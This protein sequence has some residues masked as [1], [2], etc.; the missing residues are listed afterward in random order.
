MCGIC[1]I[2]YFDP[3]R[4]V[5]EGEIRF[6][7]DAQI[8]RGPDDEGLFLK[9]NIGLGHRRLS[10]ID[11]EK[12]HQPIF[13][14]D[15]SVVTLLNGEIYNFQ[16]I[17]NELKGFGHRFVTD[18][19]T[20]ILVHGYEE[21]GL[22]N[23][24][25][26][27]NGMFAFCL[28]DIRHER[29]F[30]V[31]D[32]L[33]K[34]PLYY[35][36]REDGL[37]FAS[38]IRGMVSG[39]FVRK[40]INPLALNHYVRLHYSFGEESLLK[41]I[42]RVMPGHLI[43]ID[44]QRRKTDNARYWLL[45][46]KRTEGASFPELCDRLYHLLDDSV[47]LRRIADVPV[48]TFLSGGL[49]STLVT[50]LLAQ[51]IQPLDTFSIGFEESGFDES[52]DSSLASSH[53]R[54][55]HHPFLLTAKAFADL[56]QEVLIRVD[57]PVADAACIPTYWLSRE[58]RKTVKVVLTGEGADEL[59]AGYDYYQEIP[60]RPSIS[61]GRVGLSESPDRDGLPVSQLSRIPFAL[62]ENVHPKIIHPDLRVQDSLQSFY[63]ALQKNYRIHDGS[64]LD[65]AQMADIGGW[66][67]DD[68][69]MKLDKMSMLHSLEIRAPF[70]DYRLVEFAFTVP[71]RHR[72]YEGIE[73]YILRETF[74]EFL[75]GAIYQKKKQGFNLPLRKWFGKELSPLLHHFLSPEKIRKNGFFDDK[76]VAAIL[77]GELREGIR[78][79]RLLFLLLV[80]QMW[81]ENL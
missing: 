23:L 31:R 41:G 79:E 44:W 34:K 2:I 38:E 46:K 52:S 7:N 12:G 37:I 17:R 33:G 70:L 56:L 81:W 45:E 76:T 30:L 66:L 63:Q 69:L 42:K 29:L 1:G 19:D 71:D 60:P 18:T 59:F 80:L 39:G 5:T 8:H 10:I 4:K 49:D 14:E 43:H 26:R 67:V 11:I 35:A 24:L 55:N 57:E 48:G 16:E 78:V 61:S 28:Y 13:N 6:L 75:P 22:G 53:Y 9:D 72:I 74:R 25:K 21:W 62:S 27:C 3:Q 65:E 47:R 20:E 54:T 36:V 32:R 40:E 64:C 68:I 15:R 77:S 50:G 73:K 51:R 58:A